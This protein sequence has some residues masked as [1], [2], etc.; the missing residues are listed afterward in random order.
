MA[1]ASAWARHL[2]HAPVMS[3]NDGSVLDARSLP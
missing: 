1:P 3:I 2:D